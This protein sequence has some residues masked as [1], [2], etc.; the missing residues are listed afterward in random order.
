MRTAPRA[1][2]SL[3]SLTNEARWSCSLLEPQYVYPP[4]TGSRSPPAV[5]IWQMS[6]RPCFSRSWV[7]RLASLRQVSVIA[8]TA[9]NPSALIRLNSPSHAPGSSASATPH[10]LLASDSVGAIRRPAGSQGVFTVTSYRE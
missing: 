10:R 5:W 4:V 1:L 8:S 9:S 7:K 3:A 6:C 2:A